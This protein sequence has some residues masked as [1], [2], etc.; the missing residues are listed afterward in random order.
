M[1]IAILILNHEQTTWKTGNLC[2]AHVH[3][4]WSSCF[5]QTSRG[6]VRG[7]YRASR[8]TGIAPKTSWIL[9]ILPIASP[10]GLFSDGNSFPRQSP[11]GVD[12]QYY[13]WYRNNRMLAYNVTDTCKSFQKSTYNIVDKKVTKLHFK[14][15]TA[16]RRHVCASELA[17]IEPTPLTPEEQDMKQNRSFLEKC[18]IF[19]QFCFGV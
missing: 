1:V 5:V 3:V 4:N 2:Q 17:G 19:L 14:S 18:Q 10:T 8:I 12:L 9:H 13:P 15:S 7:T 6:K 16:K 11:A